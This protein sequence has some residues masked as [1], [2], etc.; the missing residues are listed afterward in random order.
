MATCRLETIGQFPD[1]SPASDGSHL[2]AAARLA[3]PGMPLAYGP[4]DIMASQLSFGSWHPGICYFAHV[5]GSV[6][7]YTTAADTLVLGALAHR[8]DGRVV[9]MNSW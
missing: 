3:G 1:D 4:R 5:D 2:P 6:Y 9:T 8:C 7:G